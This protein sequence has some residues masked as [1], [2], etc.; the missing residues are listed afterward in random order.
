MCLLGY[1]LK[2]KKQ[3]INEIE[4]ILSI[5]LTQ[6]ERCRTAKSS[7]KGEISIAVENMY[8][9]SSVPGQWDRIQKCRHN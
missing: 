6:S 2:G 8:N 5:S 4:S 7:H 9:G 3:K 1:I